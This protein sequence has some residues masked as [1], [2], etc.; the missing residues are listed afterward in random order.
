MI[1]AF[2]AKRKADEVYKFVRSEK[3][4]WHCLEGKIRGAIEGGKYMCAFVEEPDCYFAE[5]AT[6]VKSKLE[7]MGYRVSYKNR[8]YHNSELYI[9]NIYWS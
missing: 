8:C 3:Y 5:D 9:F 6:V 7:A 1:D 4:V 2:E